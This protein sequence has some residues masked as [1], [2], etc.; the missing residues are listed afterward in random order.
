MV[1]VAKGARKSYVLS[2]RD[3]IRCDVRRLTM[4]DRR[5][6]AAGMEYTADDV[7]DEFNRYV[8]EYSLFKFHR[9]YNSPAETERKRQDFGNL[10]LDAQQFQKV[11][12]QRGY[13]A[14]LHYR[15]Y[16]GEL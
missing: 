8:L 14:R 4:I 3:R 2:V 11:Q 6:E 1:A 7:I 12:A 15:G 5:L 16:D 13:Y 10:S 9:A